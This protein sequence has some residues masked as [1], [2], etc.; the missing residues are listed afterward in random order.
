MKKQNTL[1]TD[2][3]IAVV[4][5][6][7]INGLRQHLQIRGEDI[8]NPILLF[9]HGGPGNPMSAMNHRFQRE[10]EKIFT[11]VN[12]DQRGCGLSEAS[13]GDLTIEMFVADICQVAEYLHNILPDRPIVILGQSWGSIVGALA[14]FR[15]PEHF[16]AYI[17]TGQ[18]VDSALAFDT[19]YRHA[20]ECAEA[21]GDTKLLEGLKADLSMGD[22]KFM[23]KYYSAAKSKYG[24]ASTNYRSMGAIAKVMVTEILTCPYMK[25]T[26][27][28]KMVKDTVGVSPQYL[29]FAK[30]EQ[31]LQ[32]RLEDHTTEYRIPYYNI[33]GDNDWQT[34]YVLSKAYFDKVDA[35]LKKWFTLDHCGHMVQMDALPQFTQYLR[36]IRCELFPDK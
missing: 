23:S 10:W 19:G 28:F 27:R 5:K 25:L 14:A 9:V 32:Y 6:P 8:N 35:P 17:G 30:G 26:E 2:T 15:Y 13:D 24:F 20:M 16:A 34:P 18:V 7:M 1:L 21:D 29:R 31:F 12:W 36:Q 33:N 4:D 3:G 11:V 22:Q